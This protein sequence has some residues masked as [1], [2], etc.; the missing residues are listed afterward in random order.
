MNIFLHKLNAHGKFDDLLT[1]LDSLF[2]EALECIGEKLPLDEINIDVVM[3][4]GNF[5]IPEF[6]FSGYSPSSKQIMLFF[7]LNNDNLN[8]ALNTEF[9]PSLGHEI[10]HCFRHKGVGYGDTLREALISEGLACHFETELRNGDIPFY[11][12]AINQDMIDV[13]HSRMLS[14]TANLNYDHNAWFF[15]TEPDAIP[16]HAGYTLGYYIVSNYIN[17]TGVLASQLWN[18]SVSE[19]FDVTSL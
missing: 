6:G 19:F 14:E 10:H 13:L 1:R 7:D 16:L 17:K 2:D 5:V 18:V 8:S 12:N 9:I 3:S 15:G 4:E 11:A